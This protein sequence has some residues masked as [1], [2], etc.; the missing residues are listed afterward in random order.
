MDEQKY[1]RIS[2]RIADAWK[3]SLPHTDD[4]S[5]ERYFTAYRAILAEEGVTEYD[6][7]RH[8]DNRGQD[9]EVPTYMIY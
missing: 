6:W 8:L 9:T 3:R 2:R 7:E 5:R 1:F 4:A